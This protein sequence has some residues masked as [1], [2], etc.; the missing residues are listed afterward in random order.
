MDGVRAAD[1]YLACACAGGDGAAIRLFEERYFR[2]LDV[3]WPSFQAL[4]SR[5][6]ARQILRQKLFA[7]NGE[8]EPKV[9]TFG[10]KG[11]LRGW[12][13][14]VAAR[15]LA[16][17]ATKARPERATEDAFF[18]RMSANVD[19]ELDEFRARCGA[20]FKEAFR[21]A[22]SEL[23]PR[24]RSLLRHA[25][26]RSATVVEIGTIYGVHGATA[27]RWISAARERLVR[28]VHARLADRMRLKDDELES[29]LRLIESAANVTIERYLREH[30]PD[31]P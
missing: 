12:V 30:E 20:E 9:A 29:V 25:Y 19:V 22:A 21:E 14:V 17:A 31:Q 16:D 28:A 27:A 4:V 1:L 23:T 2:E 7:T 18:E 11:G 24:D 6:D 10:G 8:K 5:E 3:L 13:R 15:L 26:V